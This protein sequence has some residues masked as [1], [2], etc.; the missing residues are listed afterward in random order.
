MVVIIGAGLAG[1]SCATRLAL[2]QIPFQIFEASDQ[3][4]GR[5]RTDVVEG[6]RL[7]RG[8]QILL[9]AYP[10]AEKLLD[11]KT[12]ELRPLQA[13]ALVWDGHALRRLSDPFRHPAQIPAT[14]GSHLP[15]LRDVPALVS[16]ALRTLPFSSDT[17]LRE[18]EPSAEHSTQDDLLSLGISNRLREQFFR[19]FFAGIF[20]ERPLDT[21]STF[22]RFLF[23]MFATG[24]AVVPKLGMGEIPRLL[25][26][27]LPSG[28]IHLRHSVSGLEKQKVTLA[29]GE[30]I[31]ARAV[32]VATDGVAA[33]RLLNRSQIRNWRATECFWFAAP[34]SPL[35]ENVLVLDGTGKGAINHLAVMSD[36]SESYAPPGKSLICANVVEPFHLKDELR[37]HAVVEQM[38]HWFG[39]QVRDWRLL[40]RDSIPHAL[41]A[42]NPDRPF[43]RDGI[44][45]QGEGVFC[46]GD[47]LSLP[48][49]EGA[50]S[51]GLHAADEVI[52][53]LAQS[54]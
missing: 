27:Q 37:R 23:K 48:S 35:N 13:G 43:K 19:P 42:L 32:V 44:E 25:A 21:S 11:F 14:L 49:Q 53:L 45:T 4:G 52:R 31:E 34:R 15:S 54:G 39:A 16:L 33:D 24:S 50:A 41:P 9:T 6:F 47:Y 38:E 20:L 10:W 18:R 51:S 26:S 46:C 12:L 3:V 8:F 29:S 30:S 17:L 5:M 7:D 22:F 2:H 28:S 40:R 1:L 36:V